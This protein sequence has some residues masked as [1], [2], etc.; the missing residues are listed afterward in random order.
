[1]KHKRKK[2]VYEISAYCLAEGDANIFTITGPSPISS[3]LA[4]AENGL[5]PSRTQPKIFIANISI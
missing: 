3:G 2:L 1:M 5:F 4:S